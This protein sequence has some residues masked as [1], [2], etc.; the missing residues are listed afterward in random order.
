[1]KSF[2]SFYIQKNIHTALAAV[3]FVWMAFY[4]FQ[5]EIS[6]KP[7][8]FTFF[9]SIFSYNFTKNHWKTI[10]SQKYIFTLLIISLIGSISFL[11]IENINA[12]AFLFLASLITLFYT[13]NFPFTNINFRLIPY[14]KVYLVPLCWLFLALGL[15]HNYTVIEWNTTTLLHCTKMYLFVFILLIIFELKDFQTDETKLKTIPQIIGKHQVKMFNLLLII[16]YFSLQQKNGQLTEPHLTVELF[17]SFLLIIFTL[18]SNEKRPMF[19]TRFIVESTPILWFIG[20][21]IIE[22]YF[23]YN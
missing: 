4:H 13:K 23:F 9:A 19:F 21:F 22:K 18:Y 3:C 14:I 11:S 5:V 17:I 16:C 15:L 2:F 1:M 6:T 7:L 20:Y 12:F 10:F 8:I